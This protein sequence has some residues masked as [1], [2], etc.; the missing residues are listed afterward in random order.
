MASDREM[1]RLSDAVVDI[2]RTLKALVK[3]TEAMTTTL[4]T[5]AEGIKNIEDNTHDTA[6]T[7]EAW[8]QEWKA[9]GL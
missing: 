4:A 2:G 1:R 9:N 6:D 5:M 7:V 8:N 3:V